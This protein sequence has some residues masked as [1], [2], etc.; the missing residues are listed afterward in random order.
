MTT[1]D[2]QYMQLALTN[3]RAAKGQTAPNPLVG[4][5]IVNHNEIVGIGAHLKAGEAHAEI[6]AL[7]MAGEKARG[8]TVYVTLEPCAHTGKTGPCA[9]ALIDANV[10]KVFVA[11]RDP[12]RLVAG[13]GIHMLEQAGIEVNVGLCEQ[14]AQQLNEV[15]NYAIVKHMPFVTLKA[16]MTLD[17]KIS[18]YTADSQWITSEAA[19]KDVHHLRH[20]HQAIAVGVGTVLKDN[21]SLTAR[22]ENGR[23]PLRI[24]VDSRLRTPLDAHVVCDGTAETWIFTASECDHKKKLAL[25][26]KKGVRIFHTTGGSEVNL[27]DMLH[28]LY[29][30]GITSLLLEAGG[31][32]N[33]AFL[34]DSLVQ[35]LIVYVAPK[36]IGGK[37]APT[38]FEGAGL[39]AMSNAHALD[40]TAFE[41]IGPDLK[42]T[43]YPT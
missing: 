27:R 22:I 31:T 29:E 25:A 13:K 35:K 8:S 28:T 12:N 7:R 20:E 2:E 33:A 17:G 19:R 23:H 3:A 14:E 1:T 39:S 21:P 18:A 41:Q 38:F 32:L 37:N 34:N 16:A 10:K 43:C 40:M 36:L 11:T 42:I 4:A 9:Q 6:H 26:A 24:I 5:V 15:F 30:S